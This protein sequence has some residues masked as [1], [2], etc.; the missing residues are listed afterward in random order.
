[1]LQLT[2]SKKWFLSHIIEPG[3][4]SCRQTAVHFKRYLRLQNVP[5]ETETFTKTKYLLRLPAPTQKRKWTRPCSCRQT[6][7]QEP[8]PFERHFWQL[9]SA[10]HEDFYV[11]IS[12]FLKDLK[13]KSKTSGTNRNSSGMKMFCAGAQPD[14]KTNFATQWKTTQHSNW[15]NYGEIMHHTISRGVYFWAALVAGSRIATTSYAGLLW[16]ASIFTTLT[17]QQERKRT[18]S[19]PFSHTSPTLFVT[20]VVCTTLTQKLYLCWSP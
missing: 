14:V 1:M 4:R 5:I 10:I 17:Q 18:P 2:Q 6:H 13:H 9:F 7:W 16:S 12:N 11:H 20:K 19:I 3:H 15:Q 8:K